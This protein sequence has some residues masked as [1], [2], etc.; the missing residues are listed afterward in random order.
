[1]IEF[2]TDS[3]GNRKAAIVPIELFERLTRNS[4]L[5]ELWESVSYEAGK[6]DDAMI[7]G[8]VVNIA[9][10]K[11]V[12]LHAAWR[13]YRKLTQK[14]VAESMGITQASVSAMEKSEKPREFNLA[15]LAELY[16]CTPEQLT[17]D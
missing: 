14:Q 16:D 1:M 3:A 4:D 17:D 7:P 12:T 2:I 8:D 5:P 10:E 6:N 13:I 15:R 9:I 11:G